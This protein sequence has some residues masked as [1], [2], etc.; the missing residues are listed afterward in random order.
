VYRASSLL[1]SDFAQSTSRHSALRP[2]H[3]KFRPSDVRADTTDLNAERRRSQRG[4]MRNILNSHTAQGAAM[5][6]LV[7]AGR[8]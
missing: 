5:P 3:G 6:A 2:P 7:G 8:S 1:R 4:A